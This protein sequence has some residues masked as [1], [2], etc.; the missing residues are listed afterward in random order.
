MSVIADNSSNTSLG[1][2]QVPARKLF[3]EESGEDDMVTITGED[4]M[5]YQVQIEYYIFYLVYQRNYL[6]FLFIKETCLT[7]IPI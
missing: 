3:Q 7:N 4:G 5:I 6:V 2:I 1:T